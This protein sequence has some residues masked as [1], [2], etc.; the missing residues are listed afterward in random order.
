MST[1]NN[2]TKVKFHFVPNYLFKTVTRPTRPSAN[3]V[4]QC[5]QWWVLLSKEVPIIRGNARALRQVQGAPKD[6]VKLCYMLMTNIN[7]YYILMIVK[8]T[9]YTNQG[10]SR[11]QGEEIVIKIITIHTLYT[12]IYAQL[13]IKISTII[14]V[15]T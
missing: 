10:C 5:N 1:S 3:N 14:K 7:L 6:F 4:I 2:I 12:N 13:N 8:V 15:Y 11:V 9:I